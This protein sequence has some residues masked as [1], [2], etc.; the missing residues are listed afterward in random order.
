MDSKICV[1][2]RGGVLQD[3][4]LHLETCIQIVARVAV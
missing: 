2:R 3:P 1:M 4:Y